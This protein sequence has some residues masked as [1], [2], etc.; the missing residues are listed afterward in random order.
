MKVTVVRWDGG[1]EHVGESHIRKGGRIPLG[2]FIYFTGQS[3]FVVAAGYEGL[4]PI[5]VVHL[6]R[7]YFHE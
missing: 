4:D 7:V 6:E 5:P 2:E 3:Y 1:E